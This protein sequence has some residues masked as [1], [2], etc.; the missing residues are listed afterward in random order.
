MILTVKEGNDV[1]VV[2]V[3]TPDVEITNRK[4]EVL[5]DVP[6]TDVVIKFF[7]DSHGDM[8]PFEGSNKGYSFK[9]KDAHVIITSKK[10]TMFEEEFE[11]RQVMVDDMIIPCDVAEYDYK[12]A[13]NYIE[14]TGIIGRG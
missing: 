7:W 9:K 10:M 2:K 11:F 5:L 8:I 3:E 1:K 6:K 14:L 13:K 12:E 4:S